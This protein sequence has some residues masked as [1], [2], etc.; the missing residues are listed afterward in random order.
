MS[1]R[2][3][4]AGTLQVVRTLATAQAAR[5][6]TVT[7]AYA[8]RPESPADLPQLADAGVELV[9]LRGRAARRLSQ[10]AAGRALRRIVRERQPDLVHL[11]SSFAGAV[12]ALALPR[13][14]V[15]LIYTPHGVAVGARGRRAPGERGGARGR[16]ARGAALHARRRG[17]GGGGGGRPSRPARAARRG[18]PQ[19]HPRA[20]RGAAS[21]R[22]ERSEPVVVAAGRITAQRRPAATAR[23]LSALAPAAR[24]SWIGGASDGADAVRP[25]GGHPGDRLA[26]A[27]A[28]RSRS[29][30]RRPCTCTGRSGTG[31]RWRCSRRSR[32]TSSS[33]PPTSRRTA[34]SRPA[35]GVRGRERGD[36]ARAGGARR[37]VLCAPSCSQDQRR[38]APAFSARRMAAEWLA[39]LPAHACSAAVHGWVQSTTGSSRL[40]RSVTHGP[41]GPHRAG[42]EATLAGAR[43][44]GDHDRGERA[45]D[46]LPSDRVR[47]DRRRSR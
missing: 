29:S 47:V 24:V 30:P 12:G 11:H 43:R 40:L 45:R 27:R 19:R 5:G 15:P 18:R 38:R 2:R 37:C 6:H 8:D 22:H 23:I 33:S 28:R 7:L 20:R 42:L 41:K 26:A 17:V 25:R 44:D 14:T 35:A 32:A 1:P 13:G 3:P 21:R 36:R 16:V 46:P 9:A 10:L 4:A 34:R 39:T 31:S